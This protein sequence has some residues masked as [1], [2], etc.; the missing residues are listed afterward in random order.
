MLIYIQIFHSCPD[1]L[2]KYFTSKLEPVKIYTAYTKLYNDDSIYTNQNY[3]RLIRNV[4][5]YYK[6]N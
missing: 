4:L 3:V 2:F 6:K 1:N 5:W